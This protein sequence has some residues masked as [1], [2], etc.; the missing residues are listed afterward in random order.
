MSYVRTKCRLGALARL[1]EHGV[2]D[3]VA[4][5]LARRRA[6]AFHFAGGEARRFAFLVDEIGD[7]LFAAP[8]HVMDAGIDDATIGAE[9]L[10]FQIADA[11]DG[12][13]VIHADLVGKLLGIKRPAFRV[14][15]EADR[16]A[17][18]REIL[19]R[20]REP[21]LQLM[22]RQAFVKHR[23]GQRKSR[24]FRAVVQIEI[25][26]AGPRSVERR[27]LAEC[28]RGAGLRC[29]RH[30][31]HFERIRR[32]ALEHGREPRPNL[33]QPLVAIGNDLRLAVV[34]VGIKIS[35]I[36][37]ERFHALADRSFGQTLRHQQLV[38]A[39]R[40][41]ARLIEPQ[42]MDF[43][44]RHARRR[45]GLEC[46]AIE[47]VAVLQLPHARR[48]IGRRAAAS[49]SPQSDGPARARS[50][51]YRCRPPSSHSLGSRPFSFARRAIEVTRIV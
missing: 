31:T 34:G 33:V 30:A 43:V 22:A 27:S 37:I 32:Q 18:E 39:R 24:P 17:D 23:G 1:D 44:R 40:D 7:R 4:A 26:D 48:M 35:R 8:F 19:V 3:L 29:R 10:E 21:A 5:G 51:T 46:R 38:D 25:N 20:K 36:R 6:I 13:V 41:F 11:A 28:G 15:G 45:R 42:L 9:Q 47:R 16:L 12:I 14:T 50:S 2:P 49:A